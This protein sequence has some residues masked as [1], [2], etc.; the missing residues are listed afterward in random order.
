MRK[1][2]VI[3]TIFL[4]V[5]LFMSNYSKGERVD[6]N[7]SFEAKTSNMVWSPDVRLTYEGN[8][9]FR[10][11]IAIDS[12]DNIHVIWEDL[13]TG[14]CE[15][16][17]KR[18]NGTAWSEAQRLDLIDQGGSFYADMAVGNND[19]LHVCWIDTR[20]SIY[21]EIYYTKFTGDKWST[22]IPVTV[23]ALPYTHI[24]NTG[25]DI[26][27]DSQGNIYIFWTIQHKDLNPTT[28]TTKDIA[29]IKYDGTSWSQIQHATWDA[30]ADHFNPRVAVDSRDNLHLT[31]TTIDEYGRYMIHY[32]KFDGTSWGAPIK[33]SENTY[34][35]END[36]L[37]TLQDITVDAQDNLH[38]VW[39]DGR[40]FPSGVEN[41]IYYTKLDN[42]GN[43]ITND[44]R[45]SNDT[46][47]SGS[48]KDSGFPAIGCDKYNNLHLFWLNVDSNYPYR[49]ATIWY[50]KLNS[51]GDHLT[52]N[53]C[54]TSAH[55]EHSGLLP[56][57]ALSIDSTNNPH[58][59]FA[60]N[61]DGNL[62]IYY[63]HQL[64]HP[65]APPEI[66][67][68]SPVEGEVVSGLL[69]ITGVTTPSAE[70]YPLKK[71]EVRI[72]NATWNSA[73]LCAEGT[74]SWNYYWDTTAVADGE[75]T[76][77]ARAFDGEL[78]SN[79]AKVTV[80][81]RNR[82]NT[83][84][85]CTISSPIAGEEIKGLCK[86][87]GTAHDPDEGDAITKVEVKF[88]NGSWHSG[89]LTATGT[90]FW[91]YEWDTTEVSNGE[92]TIQARAFDGE[93]YSEQVSM[94]VIVNNNRNTRPVCTISSPKHGAVVEGLCLIEGTAFDPDEGDVIEIVDVKISNL[95]WS[96]GWQVAEGTETWS[97]E[98]DTKE[99]ANGEYII[100]AR[101]FDG[102]LYSDEISIS[103]VVNNLAENRKPVCTIETPEPG[104][105]IEGVYTIAGTAADPDEN[106]EI[107]AVYVKTQNDWIRARGTTS[108]QYRWDTTHLPNGKY[109]IHAKAFDGDLYS[110][111]VSVEVYV[112]NPPEENTPPKCAISKPIQNEQISGIYEITGTAEDEETTIAK[113]ELKIANA[114]WN[115]GWITAVGSSKWHYE[116]DTTAVCNGKY[117]IYA[118]AF[119]GELYS[120]EVKIE[121][122]VKNI[123]EN[124]KPVCY[125]KEPGE[126]AKVSGI[127]K[128]IIEASDFD[129]MVEK[130]QIKIDN[131]EW[132][133][134]KTANG[135][136]KYLW[137][138]TTVEN[139][140]HTIYARCFDGVE[141]SEIVSVEVLVENKI[142]I[143]DKGAASALND[144]IIM[145]V[146]LFIVIVCGVIVYLGRKFLVQ[147]KP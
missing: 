52:Q 99:V 139:G 84:P 106:D 56:G 109:I 5:V 59:V 41:E 75:Y 28:P 108:W 116:W 62:E 144:Y 90:N 47:I 72:S 38:I 57:P 91:Y 32:Q 126:D 1:I 29:Y 11:K 145:A 118:R 27:M 80:V 123:I 97:Y 3:E 147:R 111:M 19:E 105:A 113:V 55:H 101:A 44:R 102:E 17:Y 143:E 12:K 9:S 36:A 71:V 31:Y 40:D 78:Y 112:N 2:C 88:T 15:V 128:I 6:E 76:I 20:L 18:Y 93:E 142:P 61:R 73:W 65:R 129:G 48:I 63:K 120:E 107:V 121:V 103:V 82:V 125:F 24:P 130:V 58:A 68:T 114:S 138:T 96:S 140:I 49:N 134:L 4:C 94:N 64:K 104:E 33:I 115:S 51:N 23:N 85:S 26:I 83:K 22:P 136:W 92:Y 74:S 60:D 25:T 132:L 133:D 39:A 10:P 77:E 86:I 16:F 87:E 70:N 43:T 34:E 146:L 67:I 137:N 14:S 117:T 8:D 124:I 50:A 79:I 54:L 100:S 66:E 131:K 81:I 110:E 37:A 21:G 69:K 30:D 127:C 95:S 98:W 7:F 53:I 141:W 89:W 46:A 122:I 35:T 135:Y 119:D 42:N 45:I 13:R